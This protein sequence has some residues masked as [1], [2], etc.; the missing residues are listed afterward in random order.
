MESAIAENVKQII[1]DKCLK[2]GAVAAKAGYN[3]KAFSN[4]LNGRKVITDI[5][6]VNITKALGVTPNDV[7]GIQN[8]VEIPTGI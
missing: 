4:M 2:Q 6:V 8:N 5:D 7:F 3:Y 1:R